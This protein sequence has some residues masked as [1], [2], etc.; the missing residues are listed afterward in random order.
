MQLIHGR[1]GQRP[2]TQKLFE[3]NELNAKKTTM[4]IAKNRPFAR[5]HKSPGTKG[6][7]CHQA[8]DDPPAAWTLER[9]EFQQKNNT[10][11]MTPATRHPMISARN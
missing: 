8:V 7:G 10:L 11:R 1:W 4:R 6:G 3:R 2:R 9:Y 5:S